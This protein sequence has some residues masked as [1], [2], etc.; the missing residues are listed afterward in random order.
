[1]FFMWFYLYIYNIRRNNLQGPPIFQGKTMVSCRFSILSLI[2]IHWYTSTPNLRNW[3]PTLPRRRRRAPFTWTAEFVPN[4]LNETR[5]LSQLKGHTLKPHILAI[6]TT[7][8]RGFSLEW[9]EPWLPLLQVAIQVWWE[10]VVS[11]KVGI[12]WSILLSYVWFHISS[13]VRSHHGLRV[14]GDQLMFWD[15]PLLITCSTFRTKIKW[16]L[17]RLKEWTVYI[18]ILEGLHGKYGNPPQISPDLTIAT[19][20][21]GVKCSSKFC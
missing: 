4:V 7:V 11:L 10:D 20:I 1:M 19:G 15:Y 5:Q 17:A 3:F 14:I 2:S 12:W 6:R 18:N 13:W 16:F 8:S 9:L 21:P